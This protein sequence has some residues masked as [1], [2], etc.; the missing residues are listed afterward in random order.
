MDRAHRGAIHRPAW[1]NGQLSG[2]HSSA[3]EPVPWQ[4]PPGPPD[5]PDA[6]AAAAVA[7]ARAEGATDVEIHDTVLIAAVACLPIR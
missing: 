4:Q 3:L 7:K 1:R 2:A 6:Q 5:A